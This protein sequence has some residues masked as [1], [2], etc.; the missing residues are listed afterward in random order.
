MS[1]QKI[2]IEFKEW[3]TYFTFKLLK[4]SGDLNISFVIL[5]THPFHNTL[6]VTSNE[7]V[8]FK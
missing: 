1:R 5:N 2:V 8:V 6:W 4:I 7:G 3:D